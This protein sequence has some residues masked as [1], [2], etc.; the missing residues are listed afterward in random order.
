M[1]IQEDYFKNIFNTVR[2]AILILD[3]NLRV[4][5]ANRSFFRIF[6]VDAAGTIGTLLYDLGNGQW[7]I[8]LLRVLLED[9]LPNNNPADDYEIDHVFESIG[10]K[11]MLLNACKLREKPDAQPIILLAIED[12][13]ERKRLKALL[14][15]S[16]ERYR[17]IFETA[18]DGIL[19]LEKDDGRI[20]NVNPSSET[21]TGFTREESIG[22]HLQDI[23]VSVDM[24]NFP[25]IMQSLDDYG[26]LNYTDVPVKTK[27]GQEIFTDI[28]L[29]DRAK[30]AQCNIRD[31]TERKLTEDA[32]KREQALSNAIIDS[33][34]DAF[35]LLNE[36]GR[37]VRWN[38][39]LREAIIGKPEDQVADTI[40]AD[41]IHPD[42]RAQIQLKIANVLENGVVENMEARFLLRGGPACGWFLLTARQMMINARP[43]LVGVG[44]DISAQT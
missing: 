23:G 19:L 30:V 13:T 12:I 8:P 41:L 10:R 3:E 1:F 7:N 39:Y 26:I 40:V 16:E 43:F 5:S 9:V 35:Y 24:S 32:L 33:I 27:S 38:S 17:R 44:I 2:G 36:T 37:F 18:S 28:Y 34:P 29:V 25:A 31:V 14:T 20:I 4:L 15:K 42:D 11:N 22:K 6:E 21:M